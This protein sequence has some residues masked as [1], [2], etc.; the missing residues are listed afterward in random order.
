MAR[1]VVFEDMAAT[2]FHEIRRYGRSSVSVIVRMLEVIRDVAGCVTREPDRVALLAHADFIMRDSR[3]SDLSDADRA[4]VQE[5]HRRALAAL[6]RASNHDRGAGS[7]PHA[8]P[9]DASSPSNW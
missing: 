1:P 4:L 5:S 2:A 7:G 3:Q 6:A 9:E 8:P